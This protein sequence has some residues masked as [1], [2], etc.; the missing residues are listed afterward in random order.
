MS[1]A[2][3]IGEKMFNFAELTEKDFF[4]VLMNSHDKDWIY[5]LILSFNSARVDEFIS[6]MN[7]YADRIMA[8]VNIYL[9]L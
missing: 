5:Y 1:V 4:R 2:S 9:T 3:L 6:M 8:D 7:K